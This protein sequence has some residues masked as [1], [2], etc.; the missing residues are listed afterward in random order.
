VPDTP[1]VVPRPKITNVKYTIGAAGE[2]TTHY[3]MSFILFCTWFDMGA[4][5]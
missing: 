2:E 5:D 3:E 4:Q 1:G